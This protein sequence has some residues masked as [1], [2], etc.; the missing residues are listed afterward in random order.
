MK[1]SKS[2]VARDLPDLVRALNL[3]AAQGAE[4]EARSMLCDKLIS[5]ARQEGLTH[6][7]IA[8][9]AGASRT[10]VTAILNRNLHGISTDFLLRILGA[11]GYRARITL[12]K[13]KPAA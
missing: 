12:T 11:L 3:T 1:S 10:R 7:Q 6:A 9:K 2:I 13:S 5:I 8:R 4:I